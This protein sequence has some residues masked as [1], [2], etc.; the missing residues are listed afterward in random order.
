M[1]CS[2]KAAIDGCGGK[3][4]GG[5]CHIGGHVYMGKMNSEKELRA[6]ALLRVA[7]VARWV[8]SWPP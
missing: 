7:S 1:F 4:V 2:Q 6:A 5:A 3:Q 8:I